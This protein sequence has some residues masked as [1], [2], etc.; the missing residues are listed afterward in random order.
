LQNHKP[1]DILAGQRADSNTP[2]LWSMQ[3][4][5]FLKRV[6]VFSINSVHGVYLY[7]VFI[8]VPEYPPSLSYRRQHR[9]R[10]V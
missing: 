3:E 1:L 10:P 8:V 4:N 2:G 6:K 5:C 9:S 7:Q